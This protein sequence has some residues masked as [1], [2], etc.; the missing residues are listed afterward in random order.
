M[1]IEGLRGY[2][3]VIVSGLALGI[4]GIAHRA[5]LGAGLKT[6][7][8]PGSGLDRSILYPASHQNLAEEILAAGS[9]GKTKGALITEFEP[10]MKAEQWT[11][12]QRNRIMAGICDATLVI[13]ADMRSG[14]LITARLATEYNRD[15]LAVPGSIFSGSSYGPN[16]LIYRGAVPIRRPEDI[17]E[18]LGIE[19]ASEDAEA[20]QKANEE[21]SPTERNVFDLLREPLDRPTLIN[22]LVGESGMKIHE[23]SILVSLLEIKGQIAERAGLM[24]AVP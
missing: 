8:I 3:V 22:R 5:A 4:D 12:P 1:L 10:M 6:I 11:F 13:E 17:L 15:V 16:D 20:S 2:P 23:A 24:I 19:K 14:T 21:L 18:A 7:A 9:D